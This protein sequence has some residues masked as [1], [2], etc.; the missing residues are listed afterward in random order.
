MHGIGVYKWLDD[1]VYIGEY[2]D[3]HKQGYGVFKFQNGS[4]YYGYWKNG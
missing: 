4:L 1:R 3:N 2:K